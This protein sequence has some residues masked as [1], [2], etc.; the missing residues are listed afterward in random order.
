MTARLTVR[1]AGRRAVLR[2]LLFLGDAFFFRD[3]FLLLDLRDFAFG[4]DF[5]RRFLAMRAPSN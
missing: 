1:F 2:V 4:F 3:I 5:V